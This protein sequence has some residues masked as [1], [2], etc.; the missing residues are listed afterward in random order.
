MPN[1]K[2]TREKL[3]NHF[4]YG[5]MIYVLIIIVA[6]LVG[7][8]VFTMTVYKAPNPRRIDVELI[9]S[10][11]DT[12]TQAAQEA[13]GAL[14]ALGQEY[15]RARDEQAGL[16]GAEDYEIP[17]QEVSFLS[18]D[19]D[20][21]SSSEDAYYASQK[22]L[23]TLAAQE[24]DIYVLSRTLMSDLVEQ[25]ILVPLDDYIASGVIDPGDR[26]LDRV[27][28]DAYN[29]DETA[30]GEQKIFGLQADALTGLTETFGYYPSDK[31]LCIVAFSKNQDTAAAVL[32]GMIDMF[33]PQEEA[34]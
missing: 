24:G 9:G 34:Q 32:Q 25:N 2:L 11:S 14:L 6:A 28:F 15:E 21:E 17:L 12:G 4:Q 7:N 1:T 29:D 10:Y 16:T 30:T 19:Y 20:P 3:K 27:R 31:Y 13:A 5:K 33:T 18:L 23:V 8:L 22:Y 26:D